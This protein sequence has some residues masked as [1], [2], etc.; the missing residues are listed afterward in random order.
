MLRLPASSLTWFALLCVAACTDDASSGTDDA[1]S[2]ESACAGSTQTSSGAGGEGG[3]TSNGGG[4]ATTVSGGGGQGGEGGAPWTG[5]PTDTPLRLLF[6]GNSFT[7]QGPV[8]HIVR[9]LAASVG[10]PKPEVEF[11]AP[12]GVT[13]AFHSALP[14]TLA[15]VDQGQWSFVV[16]QD[17]STR[18][19][20]NAGAPAAFK[21]D[22]T[23]FYDRIKQA[24]PQAQVV[25]YETWA[26]HPQHE[27]YPGTFSDPL[28]MQAQLRYHYN[29]AA[30]VYIP[31]NAQQSS[32]PSEVWV[33]PVGDAWEAQLGSPNALGLHASDLYH[34]NATGQYLNALVLYSSIY[35]VTAT[36]AASLGLPAQDAAVLQAVADAT[37]GITQTPP[38]F[39]EAS[40]EIGQS[41]QIDFGA[42]PTN[43]GGWNVVSDCFG[44]AVYGLVDAMGE[45]TS[46]DV[47]IS[48]AFNGSNELGLTANTL[49]YPSEVSQDACWVGSFDG[50][51]PGLSELGVVELND[52]PDGSYELVLFASRSGND[53]G[54]GR[55]TRFTVGGSSQE[56]EVSDNASNVVTFS[57][58]TPQNG[59][60]TIEV[61]VSPNGAGRFGYLGS[62]RLTKTAD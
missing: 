13:L 56:L 22:A 30:N 16:L 39:P 2:C 58:L 35:G 44:G 1:G 5:V 47:R 15:L 61:R 48:D 33:A 36:G 51:G 37:T 50:H 31:A 42:L 20:D 59:S 38:P 19:T 10:W 7:H 41:V 29:D 62:V 52:V 55:L 40:F 4:G 53:G 14:E 45:G 43:A 34:A 28:E 49:G 17:L 11:S 3:A 54:L 57:N 6:I 32:A 9:D 23:W 60:L 21:S 12:G 25:L 27:I 26:R 46:V 18:P 8:P 24:S